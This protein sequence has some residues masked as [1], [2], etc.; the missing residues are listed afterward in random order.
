MCDEMAPRG[1]S[2]TA[3]IDDVIRAAQNIDDPCFS[4]DEVQQQLPVGDETTRQRLD[5]LATDG[6][7]KRKK[8]GNAWVYWF[9][10]Y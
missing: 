7:L 8:V 9:P 4:I 10:G 3:K 6:V 2:K 5:D 1:R